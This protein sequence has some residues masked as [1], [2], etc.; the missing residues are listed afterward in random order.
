MRPFLHP[1]ASLFKE[2]LTGEETQL[3][4]GTYA[5]NL[6]CSMEETCIP[7]GATDLLENCI[8]KNQLNV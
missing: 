1:V 6:D 4:E 5:F 8:S 2:Q 7:A 3:L